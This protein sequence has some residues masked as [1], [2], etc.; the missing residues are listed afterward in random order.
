MD[1]SFDA[2]FES[3][4]HVARKLPKLVIDLVMRWRKAQNEGIDAASVRKA[5]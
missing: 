2:L 1:S 5:M 4:A 3:V